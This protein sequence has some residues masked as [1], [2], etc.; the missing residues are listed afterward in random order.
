MPA[1]RERAFSGKRTD[2]DFQIEPARP[3][4]ATSRRLTHYPVPSQA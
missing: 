1:R 3:R 2:G 4:G